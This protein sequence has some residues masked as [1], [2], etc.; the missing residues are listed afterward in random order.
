[1]CRPVGVF[2]LDCCARVAVVVVYG[3]ERFVAKVD[4]SHLNIMIIKVAKFLQSALEELVFVQ[5]TSDPTFTE[6]ELA[7]RRRTVVA[8]RCGLVRLNVLGE[9]L[10]HPSEVAMHLVDCLEPT[11]SHV[12][13]WSHLSNDLE[14]LSCSFEPFALTGRAAGLSHRLGAHVAVRIHPWEV[15]AIDSHKGDCIDGESDYR[16][17]NKH[18][19]LLTCPSEIHEVSSGLETL[20]SAVFPV[21]RRHVVF[22]WWEQRWIQ[23]TLRLLTPQRDERHI[24]SVQHDLAKEVDCVDQ[25]VRCRFVDGDV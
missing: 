22:G 9:V 8:L 11:V 16:R 15:D 2:A 12:Q 13:P 18:V 3:I 17:L 7:R 10:F 25:G 1:L 20:T 19:P 14:R 4:I 6:T 23:G 5:T 21:A 24:F